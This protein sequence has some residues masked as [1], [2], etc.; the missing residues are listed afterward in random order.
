MVWLA[1]DYLD[2][3]VELTPERQRH[4]QRR[5]GLDEGAMRAVLADPDIVVQRPWLPDEFLLV[6]VIDDPADATHIVVAVV[7]DEP[8][9]ETSQPRHLVATAYRALAAPMGVVIWEKS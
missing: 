2:V 4:A 5:H 3:D 6:R 9:S 7:R 8:A 1:C